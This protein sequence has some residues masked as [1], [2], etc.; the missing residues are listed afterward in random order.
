L[1]FSGAKTPEPSFPRKRESMRRQ[2]W[3]PAL[4]ESSFVMPAEAGIQRTFSGF[5][6]ARE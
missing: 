6:L 1:T 3:I 2:N 4:Y 5:P